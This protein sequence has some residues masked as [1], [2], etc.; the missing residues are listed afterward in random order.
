MI[1]ERI[2]A[3]YEQGKIKKLSVYVEK[4][5]ITKEQAKEIEKSH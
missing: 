1:F 4:G 2:K 3:L 5:L